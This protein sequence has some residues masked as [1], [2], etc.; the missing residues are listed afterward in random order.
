MFLVLIR[1]RHYFYRCC[2]ITEWHRGES[3]SLGLFVFLSDS[4]DAQRKEDVMIHEYGHTIQ[5]LMLGVLYL[6]IIG[7]PS[8]I[9]CMTPYFQRKRIRKNISYYSF[10]PERWADRLGKKV[11]G[12]APGSR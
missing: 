7:V 12:K 3:A 2:I 6:P 4:L 5:S 10:Y 11:T 1:R 9:W 8:M